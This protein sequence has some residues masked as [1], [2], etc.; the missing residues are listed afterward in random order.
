MNNY[1]STSRQAEKHLRLWIYFLPV[2]GIFPSL[3]TLYRNKNS[4][5]FEL[6]ENPLKDAQN[7]QQQQKASRQSVRITLIWLCS[8]ILLSYGAVS[9]TEIVSFRFLYANAIATTGYFI[10]CTFLMS[11]LGKEKLF[12]ADKMN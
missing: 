1:L 12:C 8:Y 7:L 4:N 6:Y 11:R 3:W 10:T 9:E 5:T 2:V